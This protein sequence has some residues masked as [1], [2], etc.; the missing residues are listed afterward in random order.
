MAAVIAHRSLRPTDAD[1]SWEE[2]VTTKTLISAMIAV[3]ALLLSKRRVY[4]AY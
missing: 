1:V 4:P 2:D 3:V